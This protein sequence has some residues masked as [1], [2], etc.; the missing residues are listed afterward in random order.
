MPIYE[1][2]GLRIALPD[3]DSFR[4]QDCSGYKSLSGQNLSEMDFGWWESAKNILWLLDVKDYSHLTK[5]EKMPEY[6]L[7]NLISKA[8]DSLLIL[9]AVWSGTAKGQEICLDL[10]PSCRT[11]PRAPKRLKL[12]FVLKLTKHHRK[13][14]LGP[15][16][17]RLSA[18][19]KGRIALFDITNVTLADHETA[20]K[21]GLPISAI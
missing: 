19:L 6:L 15:L 2:S 3:G 12:V 7:E 13:T 4:F 5:K 14:D 8:A 18:R 20:L 10:P 16:K 11:F 1:E 17:T 21:M 9:S